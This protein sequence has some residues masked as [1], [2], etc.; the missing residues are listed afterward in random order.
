[1]SFQAFHLY[2]FRLEIV[3]VA[4]V[5]WQLTDSWPWRFIRNSKK[6]YHTFVNAEL[7]IVDRQEMLARQKLKVYRTRCPDI[8]LTA[9]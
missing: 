3:Q 1:M 6:L 4:L 8:D 9:V 5:L 2:T 7:S